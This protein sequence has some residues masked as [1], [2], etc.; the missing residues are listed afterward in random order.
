MGELRP[1]QAAPTFTVRAPAQTPCWRLRKRD[2]LGALALACGLFA[3]VIRETPPLDQTFSADPVSHTRAGLLL[4]LAAVLLGVAWVC[5]RVW[6]NAE[7]R[8]D[9]PTVV[10]VVLT[11]ATCVIGLSV[12]FWTLIALLLAFSRVDL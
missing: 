10:R 11:M 8:G 4:M 7:P 3:A 2:S 5:S 1:Y 6:L 12:T 9:V